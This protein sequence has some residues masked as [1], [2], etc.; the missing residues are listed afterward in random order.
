[1]R[2]WVEGERDRER[3]CFRHFFARLAVYAACR[4][5][6]LVHDLA[7]LA[8]KAAIAARHSDIHVD[9]RLVALSLAHAV[10]PGAHRV[11]EGVLIRATR[12]GV[13]IDANGHGIRRKRGERMENRWQREE[14]PRRLTRRRSFAQAESARQAPRSAQ[15]RSNAGSA[16]SA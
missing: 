7:H 5:F 13:V 8:V 3:K 15:I 11:V 2:V 12:G 6:A 9:A 4:R 1:M 16:E 10:G 14:H